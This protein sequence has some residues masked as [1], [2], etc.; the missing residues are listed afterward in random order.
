MERHGFSTRKQALSSAETEPALIILPSEMFDQS[1]R[2][3]G[4]ASAA[5][6]NWFWNFIISRFSKRWPHLITASIADSH[7]ST[8]DVPY[9]GPVWL[10]RVFLLRLHDDRIDCL[11]LLPRPGD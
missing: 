4:Q 1:T 2:S 7:F 11:R 6:N 3:L 5:A 9:H 10:R 8:A